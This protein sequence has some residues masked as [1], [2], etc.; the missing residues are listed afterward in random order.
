MQRDRETEVS[1]ERKQIHI[2]NGGTQEVLQYW[3]GQ[4]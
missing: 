4:Y 1:D 3:V 2:N